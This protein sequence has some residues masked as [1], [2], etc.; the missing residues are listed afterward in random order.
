[1]KPTTADF[2]AHNAEFNL[3]INHDGAYYTYYRHVNL[4]II[5]VLVRRPEYPFG[6]IR[7]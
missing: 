1:M 6:A 5:L 4:S 2:L 3:Q 7:F